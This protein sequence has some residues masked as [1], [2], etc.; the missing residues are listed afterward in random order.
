[1]LSF[2][3]TIAVTRSARS[4]SIFFISS[5]YLLVSSSAFKFTDPNFSLS[6]FFLSKA[7]SWS[8]GFGS[9]STP[10]KFEFS[11]ILSSFKFNS[12]LILSR[13]SFFLFCRPSIVAPEL[14]FL[15]LIWIDCSWISFNCVLNISIFWSVSSIIA[16]LSIFSLSEILKFSEIWPFLSACALGWFSK[17][18]NCFDNF[19]FLCVSSL[20][21]LSE[22]VSKFFQLSISVS[23]VLILSFLFRD[24]FLIDW[25]LLYASAYFSWSNFIFFDFSLTPNNSL[26]DVSFLKSFK[27]LSS[28]ILHLSRSVTAW[29]ISLLSINSFTLDIV[30]FTF[31]IGPTLIFTVSSAKLFTTSSTAFCSSLSLFFALSNSSLDNFSVSKYFESVSINSVF[32]S[33]NLFSFELASMIIPFSLVISSSSV[34]IDFLMLSISSWILVFSSSKL[35]SSKLSLCILDKFSIFFSLNGFTLSVKV[36]IEFSNSDILLLN[37]STSPSASV[38]ISFSILISLSISNNFK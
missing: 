5:S 9:S 13:R 21:I 4:C 3:F 37:P 7:S 26:L 30:F 22:L 32:S 36:L 10:F 25:F 38:L 14:A 2:S 28:S 19:S 34:W 6:C 8:T 1:M 11:K 35:W 17:S 23:M 18:L 20:T 33:F 15:S 12:E 29:F 24:S 31:F 16:S 27:K